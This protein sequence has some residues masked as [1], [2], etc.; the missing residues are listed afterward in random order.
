ML[1]EIFGC[2]MN[3]MHEEIECELVGGDEAA[4]LYVLV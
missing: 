4:W 3:I 1:E 2:E